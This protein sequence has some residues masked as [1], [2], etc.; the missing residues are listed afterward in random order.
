MLPSLTTAANF[1][2]ANLNL[3]MASIAHKLDIPSLLPSF[4]IPKHKKE[5]TMTFNK[6]KVKIL[7]IVP[8]NDEINPCD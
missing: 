3:H 6:I 7:F 2:N 1:H 8:R 5:S 4:D